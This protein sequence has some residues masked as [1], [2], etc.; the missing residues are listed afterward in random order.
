MVDVVE[1][2]GMRSLLLL[3][4]SQSEGSDDVALGAICM[5]AFP[6]DRDDREVVIFTESICLFFVSV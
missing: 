1:G 3:L 6:E 5:D 2:V 4:R